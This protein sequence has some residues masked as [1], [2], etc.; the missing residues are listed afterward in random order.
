MFSRGL[1]GL[2]LFVPL[3]NLVS[4]SSACTP[5]HFPFLFLFMSFPPSCPAVSSLYSVAHASPVVPVHVLFTTSTYISRLFHVFPS[6]LFMCPSCVHMCTPL[7]P[8]QRGGCQLVLTQ[9]AP[10]CTRVLPLNCS[11]L[12][13]KLELEKVS[14]LCVSS[15]TAVMNIAM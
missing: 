4:G 13:L 7:I 14:S 12:C 8:V 3:H 11:G 15:I 10:L 2:V 1:L 9:W 5:T 6:C